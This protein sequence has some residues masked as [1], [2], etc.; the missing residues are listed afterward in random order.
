[1][2]GIWPSMERF[3]INFYEEIGDDEEGRLGDLTRANEKSG[4]TS[5]LVR[6]SSTYF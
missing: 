5:I 6:R 2:V 4:Q 3:D 1:M